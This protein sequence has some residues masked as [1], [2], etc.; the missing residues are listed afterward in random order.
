MYFLCYRYTLLSYLLQDALAGIFKP[1]TKHFLQAL[2]SYSHTPIVADFGEIVSLAG[3]YQCL[4]KAHILF[5]LKFANAIMLSLS[6]P[7]DF[8]YYTHRSYI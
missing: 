3:S 5:T 6:S 2:A 7:Y 1:F 8:P 4:Q